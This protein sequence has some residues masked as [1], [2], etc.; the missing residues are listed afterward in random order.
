VGATSEARR[1]IGDACAAPSSG[2]G[3]AVFQALA[4][5]AAAYLVPAAPPEALGWALAG[6]APGLLA[7][8]LERHPFRRLGLVPFG[9]LFFAVGLV[10]AA[11]VG[12]S[13][14]TT[15]LLLGLGVGLVELP[16]LV[17]LWASAGGLG[18]KGLVF[19]GGVA[20]AVGVAAGC[21]WLD[22]AWLLPGLAVVAGLGV[23]AAWLLWARPVADLLLGALCEPMY[24][25]RGHGPGL[26][27][28]PR[29]GGVLVV[30]NHS[31]YADP[32]FIGKV[33][34]RPLRALMT[35][36]FY[37][38]PSLRWLMKNVFRAIR[39]AQAR[40]RREAP[41]LAEAA[42][43]LRAGEVVV[44]F[45]EG[46]LRRT[47]DA[48]LGPFGQGVWRILK[49]VPQTPVVVCWIEG[50]WGSFLSYCNGPPG[51][52]KKLDRRRPIDVALAAPAPLPAEV[53]ACHCATRAYLRR[54]CLEGRRLLGLDVPTELPA[55]D[56]EAEASPC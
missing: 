23:A 11:V 12:E 37:D 47:A 1:S 50:G 34:P 28:F 35:S 22:Q 19:A 15:A 24:R 40:V 39:V 29:S 27:A 49:E 31:T 45:P 53:L 46:R 30:A 38:R 10:W 9:S 8:A 18:R 32:V 13:T 3:L 5:T 44:V 14:R 6:V 55:E 48:L 56:T 17:G 4:L 52:N 36:V 2:V 7:V 33:I 20:L 41:E 21:R 54:A 43:A 25:V 16:L 51:K 26:P 42:A